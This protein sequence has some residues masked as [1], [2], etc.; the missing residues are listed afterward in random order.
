MFYAKRTLAHRICVCV[1]HENVNLLLEVLS[2]EVHGLKNNLNKFLL[3]LVCDE[4]EEHCMMS[5]C[6][7]CKNNF[8]Q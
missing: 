4:D 8:D 3:K 2:K 7:T 1:I 6:N 5:Y